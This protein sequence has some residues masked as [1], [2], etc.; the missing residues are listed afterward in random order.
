M[1]LQG[2]YHLK[3]HY[4]P[5]TVIIKYKKQHQILLSLTKKKAISQTSGIFLDKIVNFTDEIVVQC[6][7][8]TVKLLL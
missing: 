8:Q 2:G 6:D 3:Y 1:A 4:F 7:V 5:I